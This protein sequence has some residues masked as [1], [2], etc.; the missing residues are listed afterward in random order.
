MGDYDPGGSCPCLD[1]LLYLIE[2]QF[3]NLIIFYLPPP[4]SSGY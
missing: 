4:V 3:T 1:P 2:K